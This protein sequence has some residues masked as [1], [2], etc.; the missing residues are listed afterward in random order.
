MVLVALLYCNRDL[1]GTMVRI[2]INLENRYV[3]MNSSFRSEFR[4]GL[5]WGVAI[6]IGRAV[7][8]IGLSLGYDW[9]RHR[10]GN[11]ELA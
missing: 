1:E 10:K 9:A 7:I 6:W 4:L 8:G 5:G 3:E 11:V 2:G